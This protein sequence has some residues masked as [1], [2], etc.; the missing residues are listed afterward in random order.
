MMLKAIGRLSLNNSSVKVNSQSPSNFG[1]CLI[2]LLQASKLLGK[3]FQP[4]RH[5]EKTIQYIVQFIHQII[6]NV[7]S[8]TIAL[9]ST[10]SWIEPLTVIPEKISLFEGEFSCQIKTIVSF[11]PEILG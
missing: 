3:I 9:E 11:F 5:D 4:W 7:E 2:R 6:N 1:Y 10:S 8:L